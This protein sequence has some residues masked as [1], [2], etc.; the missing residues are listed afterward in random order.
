ML[1]NIFKYS[2]KTNFD[3]CT[4]TSQREKP[5]RTSNIKK[6]KKNKHEL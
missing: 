3:G 1:G 4:C 6:Q 2:N 5:P